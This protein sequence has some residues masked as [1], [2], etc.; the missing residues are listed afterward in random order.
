MS[1]MTDILKIQD[2]EAVKNS[3]YRAPKVTPSIVHMQTYIEVRT[4]DTVVELH[5]IEEVILSIVASFKFTPFWLVQQWYEVFDKKD[6]SFS[7]VYNWV[8]VGLVWIEATSL[9]LYIRPTKFLL[10]LFKVPTQ[11]YIPIPFGRLNHNVSEQQLIF[12]IQVGNK[13]SELWLN[14]K[15]IPNLLPCYHPLSIV[16]EQDSG[17][18]ILQ[19]ADFNINRFNVDVLLQREAELLSQ[20]KLCKKYTHEFIDFTYF[21]IVNKIQKDNETI[22]DTQRPDNIIPIPRCTNTGNPN[23]IAIEIE[24]SPKTLDKYNNILLNY[25]NNIKFGKLYYLCGSDRIANMIRDAFKTVKSL[26]TCELYIIPFVPPAL[27]LSNYTIQDEEF[28]KD[29]LEISSNSD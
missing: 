19:E 4:V 18:I 23:S 21:P 1:K 17:T 16:P 2:S 24:L 25:K 22:I 7:I 10:D 6:N 8:K 26:G 20:I 12:D 14:I 5:K 11:T 13:Y 15:D 27:K 3:F 29:L 9:G 28:Q